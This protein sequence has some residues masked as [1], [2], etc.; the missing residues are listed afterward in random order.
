MS[1][2]DGVI[3]VFSDNREVFLVTHAVRG[4]SGA[5]PGGANRNPTGTLN[6]VTRTLIY[7]VRFKASMGNVTVTYIKAVELRR[8]LPG[9]C[10][11]RQKKEAQDSPEC[12]VRLNEVT[13][14][15]EEEEEEKSSTRVLLKVGKGGRGEGRR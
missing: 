2:V 8:A 14:E 3:F 6:T 11:T 15:E 4:T 7:L 12:L 13:T 1:R 10:S 9:A 5:D